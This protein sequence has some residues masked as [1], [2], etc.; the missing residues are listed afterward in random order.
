MDGFAMK[1]IRQQRI[2]YKFVNEV[3]SPNKVMPLFLK[4]MKVDVT[5]QDMY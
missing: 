2:N 3:V 5:S 4:R 1:L